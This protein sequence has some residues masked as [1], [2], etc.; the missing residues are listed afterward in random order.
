VRSRE[1]ECWL[2]EQKRSKQASHPRLLLRLLTWE[3]QLCLRML[4]RQYLRWNDDGEKEWP[5]DGLS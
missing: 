4:V 5:L 3:Q 1:Q 2:Q